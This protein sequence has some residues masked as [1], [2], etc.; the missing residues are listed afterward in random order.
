MDTQRLSDLV[1][2]LDDDIDELE[3]R[4]EPLLSTA[5]SA[6]TKKLPVLDRAKLYVLVTYTI[7]SLL[8]CRRIPSN[9]HGPDH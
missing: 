2:Q 6:T 5:F 3:E 1:D 7:E 9:H 8:F 4:L